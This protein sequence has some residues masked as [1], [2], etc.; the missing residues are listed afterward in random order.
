MRSYKE[1]STWIIEYL[2]DNIGGVDVLNANFVND[3]LNF[4]GE[5]TRYAPMPYGAHKVP[6]L[7]RDLTRMYRECKLE[8]TRV[9]IQ[10][11]AGMGFPHWVWSYTISPRYKEVLEE[12]RL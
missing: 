8:R 1:R 11:F 3:Y 7:G 4:S 6:Q 10:G 2:R 5:G 12:T 9:G